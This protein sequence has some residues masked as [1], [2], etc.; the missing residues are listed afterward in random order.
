MCFSASSLTKNKNKKKTKANKLTI[1]RA[2]PL[3]IMVALC[4]GRASTIK[5]TI[6]R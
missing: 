1:P 3:G 4:T 5:I 6:L 2:G